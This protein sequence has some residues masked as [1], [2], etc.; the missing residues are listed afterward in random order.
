MLEEP[1]TEQEV[2]AALFKMAPNKPRVWMVSML[3]SSKRIG[4]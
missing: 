4:S 1:F 3:V 2:E